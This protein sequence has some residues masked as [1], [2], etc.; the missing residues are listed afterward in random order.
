MQLDSHQC[1]L[2]F[3]NSKRRMVWLKLL[4]YSM[5]REA[6]NTLPKSAPSLWHK[7]FKYWFKALSA[8]Y[9]TSVLRVRSIWGDGAPKLYMKV[10]CLFAYIFFLFFKSTNQ[11]TGKSQKGK[12]KQNSWGGLR[13]T[14]MKQSRKMGV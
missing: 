10:T 12:P 14:H 6:I 9:S 8:M 5:G 7:L 3:R 11:G 13:N 1:A 4:L 2:F